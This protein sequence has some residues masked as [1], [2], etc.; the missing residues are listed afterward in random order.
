MATVRSRHVYTKGIAALGSKKNI[1]YGTKK[2]AI[3]LDTIG[4]ERRSRKPMG[5]HLG[6]QRK[7]QLP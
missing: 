7:S 2:P 5:R 3:L 6:T 1:G 4:R